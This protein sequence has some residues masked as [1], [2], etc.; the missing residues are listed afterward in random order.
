MSST[1][2]S[3]KITVNGK[4]QSVEAYPETPLLY[5]L[6]NQLALNGPKYGCGIGQCGACMILLDNVATMSCLMTMSAVADKEIVTLAGLIEEDGQLH[7]VQQAFL[8]EQAAQC[9]YCTNGMIISAVS[10]LEQN[11]QAS[12]SEMKEAMQVNLCRCGS[13]SRVMRAI[14]RVIQ[15]R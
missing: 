10:L 1:K 8:D 3:Y 5:V 7:P 12:D 11:P 13:Q 14:K 9:G 6:R 15:S 2:E 4:K